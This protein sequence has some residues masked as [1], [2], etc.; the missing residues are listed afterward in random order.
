MSD[1]FDPAAGP[2][3]RKLLKCMMWGSAGVLWAVSG[4]VPQPFQLDGE[5]LAAGPAPGD[6]TFMQISDTHIGF[7]GPVNPDPGGTLKE[8][9]AKVAAVRPAMLLHTGDVSHLAKP[10]EFEL[11]AAIMKGANL[12][13]HYVPG[14][15]D[16]IG[17]KGKSFFER[18]GNEKSTS[19]WYS[20][21]QGGVHFIG[22]VNVVDLRP[23]GLGYLGPEQIKWLEDDVKGK[24]AST[25]IVVFAHMPLWTVSA[26]WGWGTDDAAPAIDLLKRF[27]SVTVLNG[28]IHQVIQK[29]E[30]NVSLRTA[31]STAFPQAAPDTPGASPGPL[32]VAAEQLKSMLGVRRVDVVHDKPVMLTD[33][34]LAS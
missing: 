15:H 21:D 11:A 32:K 22:L 17:D 24:S 14:E 30:G 29:V 9:L 4:G 13:T 20:F 34:T 26:N 6:F 31:Y 16:T 28:H 23:G 5:A 33:A 7:K 8:A 2:S 25:P 3:R 18:F 12:E 10:E 1:G 19:G 27:G